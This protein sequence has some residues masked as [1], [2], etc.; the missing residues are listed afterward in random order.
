[1]GCRV[2]L[3]NALER[4]M[5]D[6]KSP[7]PVSLGR[8]KA[9]NPCPFQRPAA[10]SALKRDQ[11]ERAAVLREHLSGEVKANVSLTGVSLELR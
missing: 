10:A 11:N 5:P 7:I 8:I 1:M 2:T 4:R 9:G 3:E 6:A